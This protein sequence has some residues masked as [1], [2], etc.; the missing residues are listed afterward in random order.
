MTEL[1]PEPGTAVSDAAEAAAIAAAEQEFHRKHSPAHN[2]TAPM[3]VP[4]NGNIPAGW[5]MEN[6]VN[7]GE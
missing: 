4:M 2:T 3:A 5:V 1:S 6:E 7:N